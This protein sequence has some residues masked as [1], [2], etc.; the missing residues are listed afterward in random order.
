MPGE[1][2]DERYH[3]GE[4]SVPNCDVNEN[5]YDML[6]EHT[7]IGSEVFVEDVHTYAGYQFET[8]AEIFQNMCSGTSEMRDVP[9]IVVKMNEIPVGAEVICETLTHLTY[10]TAPVTLVIEPVLEYHELHCRCCSSCSTIRPECS[11][12][13][14]YNVVPVIVPDHD[15]NPERDLGTDTQ[16]KRKVAAEPRPKGEKYVG[17][18]KRDSKDTQDVTRDKRA[19]QPRCTHGENHRVNLSVC[20]YHRTDS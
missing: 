12:S 8:A 16:R 2:A 6:L 15:Y 17:Y 11:R 13:G 5:D 10:G 20:M 19:L 7:V 1:T 4:Q 3:V 9:D 18:D 14:K